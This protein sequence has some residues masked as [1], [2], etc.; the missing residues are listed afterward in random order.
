M[1]IKIT[2]YGFPSDPYMDPDTAKRIGNRDNHLTTASC[3]ITDSALKDLGAANGDVLRIIFNADVEFFRR[4]DDTAPE[5]DPR[6]DLFQPNGFD[7]SLPDYAD[8]TV[9]PA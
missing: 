9:F 1:R 3:A 4:I 2:Q 6:I 5:S 8:V 7:K